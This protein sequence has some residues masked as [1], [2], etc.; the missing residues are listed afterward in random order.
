MRKMAVHLGKFDQYVLRDDGNSVSKAYG[1]HFCRVFMDIE[2]SR[3]TIG[4]SRNQY[5]TFMT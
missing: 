1:A 4:A 2:P 3:A 5:A